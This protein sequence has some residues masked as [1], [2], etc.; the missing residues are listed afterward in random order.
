VCGELKSNVTVTA[1]YVML[2]QALG[3]DMTL[4][5]DEL[6]SWLLSEQNED[7]SW[8]MAPNYPGDI[9]ATTEAYFALKLLGL[10]PDNAQMCQARQFILSLGGVAKVRIFTRIYLA[11]FGLFPW[12][13]V[14]ELPAELIMMPA[15]APISIY[16]LS[17]WARSTIVPLL[18]VGNHRPIYSLPNGRSET[19][20]FLDELWHIPA[21]KLVPYSPPIMELWK[22]DI[23]ALLFVAVDTV[24]YYLGGLRMSPTRGYARKKC[25]EWILEHQEKEGDWAGIFPPMHLGILALLLEGFQLDDQPIRAGLE[26]IERF[27]WHDQRGKRIQACVSPVWD[28]VLSTIA[29]CD[30]GHD[31]SRI[32]VGIEWIK[33]RQLFG[34]EG[35]WRVYKPGITPGGFSFQ[36]FNK[37]YPDIDDTAAAVLAMIKQDP[38]ARQSVSVMSAVEWIIGMQNYDGGWGAL[39]INNDKLY[40]NKI[41]FSDMDGLCDP[42]TA[43]VTGRVLEVFGLL[44]QSYK[45]DF[46]NKIPVILIDRVNLACSRAVAYLA[47]TQES[48]GAWYGRWGSNYIYGTSNVLCGLSYFS[49]RGADGNQ[50]DDE[51]KDC[52]KTAVH[53]LKMRQNS[54]GGWGE[55]LMSYKDPKL[56]G[57]GT[58]TASQTAWAL[59]GL[60]ANLSSSDKII[61]DGIRY[62]IQTQTM[63]DQEDK[64][65]SWPESEYTATGFPNHFYF[66]YSFYPHYF[67]M[68]ALG[69]YVQFSRNRVIENRTDKWY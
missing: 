9:S 42:S 49:V 66:G 27:A 28:T 43:D 65:A 32:S 22:T 44:M 56:A 3:L 17:S 45:P 15:T 1:E 39:D 63:S 29:L 31:D 16:R 69:R 51:V 53:W 62:L 47:H 10:Q 38:L 67:P 61:Q 19:N 52:V 48:T 30:A 59:M 11:T 54:D 26:A 12:K 7:G 46:D 6:I 25:V 23:T 60:L 20:D 34:P 41:P 35:D 40:L 64:E 5:R 57:Q 4:D 24:L 50:A 13:A 55:T 18:I 33:A 8:A 21:Q 36:Y 68:M 2:R 58:S 37:W 14:P